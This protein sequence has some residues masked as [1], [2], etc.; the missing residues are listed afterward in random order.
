[1]R[2]WGSVSA[3]AVGTESRAGPWIGRVGGEARACG[4]AMPG[5][6]IYVA[7]S[8]GSIGR[9]APGSL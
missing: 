4:G 9:R 5:S 7:V 3:L 6:E 8:N 1:M 2:S